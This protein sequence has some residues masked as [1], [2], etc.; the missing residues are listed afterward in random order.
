MRFVDEAMIKVDAGNGG[1]GCLSFRREKFIPR[2]G[3][4]GGDG[5][6]GGSVYFEATHGL[7]TLV[8]FRYMRHYKAENGQQG[9]GANCNGKK[10][11]D[12]ILKVPVG[13]M[14]YDVDT[15]ELIAD[16]SQ[17]GIPVLIAQGGFHGLGNTRYKSSVNR[18]PRQTSAGSPGESRHLRLELRVLADVG[19][20]GLPNAGKST[21][22]RSVSSSKAKVADYPFTTLHP[23]LGV[24]SVSIYKSF[25]M[26]DIPGLIEGAA[27]GAGLGHRFLKHLSRTCVLLHVID[28]APLDDSDPVA[29]AKA[30]VNELAEYSPE[31][32]N[33]PRW[34]VLNKTDMIPDDAE[35]EERIQTIIK[36]LQWE[37]PVFS[38]SAISGQGTQQL[39]YALMQLI[40]EMKEPEA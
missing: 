13:T 11:E 16:V 28:I 21:L 5:G 18:S 40:D 27:S 20:L 23:G 17:P 3:P 6:D 37:G 29:N 39:C 33:K 24:V 26:A 9:S 30:I 2:G 1:N 38:I 25:V 10:G 15:G 36:G 4:D 35:R 22:I 32:V 7:N 19:L 14:A 34:L 31:L 12:L 8:D